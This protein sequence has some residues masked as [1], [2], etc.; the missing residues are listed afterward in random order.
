MVKWRYFRICTDIIRHEKFDTQII[1]KLASA[2][3]GEIDRS[4]ASRRDFQAIIFRRG[5]RSRRW[6][7]TLLDDFRALITEQEVESITV[8]WTRTASFHTLPAW[9]GLITL[10]RRI[11]LILQDAASE[12]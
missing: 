8:P 2:N 3:V 9:S 1:A 6:A 10:Q 4:Q 5:G 7:F 12:W 11:S